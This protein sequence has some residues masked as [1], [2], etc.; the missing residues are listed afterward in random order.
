M[1]HLTS[2]NSILFLLIFLNKSLSF[3]ED[4]LFGFF[5]VL[6]EFLLGAHRINHIHHIN[7]GNVHLLL[8]SC[9]WS[10]CWL[11]SLLLI[12]LLLSSLLRILSHS[13]LVSISEEHRLL[14]WRLIIQ[15]SFFVFF[16]EDTINS[17]SNS[18][19]SCFLEVFFF[20]VTF[21][22]QDVFKKR[23]E[24]G[25]AFFLFGLLNS[26]IITSIFDI[27]KDPIVDVVR[28]FSS[29]FDAHVLAG[30]NELVNNQMLLPNISCQLPNSFH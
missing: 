16:D 25:F 26:N 13:S 6:V 18:L 7:R 28:P 10:F 30:W 17:L 5:F 19:G 1:V 24:D 9:K 29:F 22:I 3:W 20:A 4:L 11:Q 15:L 27:W 14:I 21:E 12:L 8:F 2:Q 23:V